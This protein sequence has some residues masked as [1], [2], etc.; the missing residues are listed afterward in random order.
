MVNTHE[1]EESYFGSHLFSLLLDLKV[2][3]PN[4]HDKV[5]L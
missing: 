1:T 4:V 5:I 3:P 2:R